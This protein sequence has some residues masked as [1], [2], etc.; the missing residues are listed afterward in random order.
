MSVSVKKIYSDDPYVHYK[1]S[2]ISPERTKAD[3]DSL[4]GAWKVQGDVHWH[5]KPEQNDVYV[6]FV[7]EE[8]VEG[9]PTKLAVK[10]PCPVIWDKAKPR[11]RPPQPEQVNWR[12]S[13]RALWW[14]LKTHL[15]MGYVMQSAKAVALLP[16]IVNAQDRTLKE[17][18]LPQI[19]RSGQFESLPSPEE[20]E[21]A[22]KNKG[23]RIIVEAR[24]REVP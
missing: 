24:G 11:S 21:E 17:L 7:L 10:I 1:G 4:L 15:E 18:V 23:N 20:M 9:V 16:Y 19:V 6:R 22:I 3:I 8:E 13:M 5:W 2:T 12:I 14:F